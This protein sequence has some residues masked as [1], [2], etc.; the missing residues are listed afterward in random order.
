[1]V[2]GMNYYKQIDEAIQSYERLR[3]YHTKSIEWIT[4]RI[5]WCWQFRKI[6]KEQMEELAGR[7]TDVMNG[8]MY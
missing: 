1:M 3:P 6:T 7:I 5:A 8:G 2:L 4:N